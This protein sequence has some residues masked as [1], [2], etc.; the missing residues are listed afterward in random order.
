MQINYGH[1]SQNTNAQ[2]RIKENGSKIYVGNNMT[3]SIIE[4]FPYFFDDFSVLQTKREVQPVGPP[5]ALSC[6]QQP[7][8]NGIS[9]DSGCGYL[10]GNRTRSA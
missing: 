10:A 5:P 4:I 8:R 2:S 7:I 1:G 9:G 6:P 3:K